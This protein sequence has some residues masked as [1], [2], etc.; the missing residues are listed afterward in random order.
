MGQIQNKWAQVEYIK[1]TPKTV[2]HAEIVKLEDLKITGPILICLSGNGTVDLPSA[3]GLAKQA[4]TYLELLVKEKNSPEH[5]TD[6]VDIIG[7]KY[8]KLN[9]EDTLGVY[10]NSEVEK[11]VKD[12]LLPLFVDE[13]KKTHPIDVA[14]KNMSQINFFT[15]CAG[16]EVLN[17]IVE[18]LNRE[19]LLKG[20]SQEEVNKINNSSVN[21]SFAPY[22][23]INNHIPSVRVISA[24]DNVVS[25]DLNFM[26]KAKGLQDLD[27]IKLLY[28]KPGQ[29]YGVERGRHTTAGSINIVSGQML[30]G[31]FTQ[32][33]EH[34]VGFVAR[35]KDWN[36]RRRRKD[37]PSPNADCV[38]QMMAW[39]LSRAVE[40]SIANYN[41]KKYIPNNFYNELM[42]ELQSIKDSFSEKDLTFNEEY[43]KFERQKKFEE[44][45]QKEI[46]RK[47]KKMEN[48]K[49][50]IKT[51]QE[52]LKNIK[53][54]TEAY[55][56]CEKF[57]FHY[58]DEIIE[59]LDFLNQSE[60]KLI[61]VLA[62]EKLKMR[63]KKENS[64]ASSL[65]ILAEMLHCSGVDDFKTLIDKYG[66]KAVADLLPDFIR[67]IPAKEKQYNLSMSEAKKLLMD[68]RES[69]IEEKKLEELP[70]DKR[71]VAELNKQKDF[72]G[73]VRVF[74]KYGFQ[75]YS[76]Y[77]HQINSVTLFNEQRKALSS[78]SRAM[79]AVEEAKKKMVQFDTYDQM[80]DKIN[81]T[82]S[83]EEIVEYLRRHNFVGVR[84]LMQE[85]LVL[86]DAERGRILRESLK[87]INEDKLM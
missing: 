86:T 47:A 76:D 20:Y 74:N 8:A 36:I 73:I 70:I 55:I 32:E 72:E 54:F 14:C 21:V 24:K 2:H 63:E 39:A 1:R 15:Y 31:F 62:D 45:R 49:P 6:Y 41:S 28:D 23:F 16:D 52:E 60:I 78:V 84:Q 38:S 48:F 22:D 40:N 35:D 10:P 57:N 42:A 81:N 75:Y 44:F 80:I 50:D 9:E 30:N 17:R 68:F 51:I 3:N 5:I 83:Y 69:K 56:M 82:D 59:N 65:D 64:K 43:K 61:K 19:L 58:V 66:G 25:D 87:F 34:N 53:T 26:L 4:E 18:T 71:L 85:N 79:Y 46:S 29:L 12:T 7:V 37:P 27:G 11:L 33:D 13:N 67:N 77:V